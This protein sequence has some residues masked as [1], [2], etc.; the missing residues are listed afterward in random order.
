M[1]KIEKD[2]LTV[3]VVWCTANEAPQLAQNLAFAKIFGVEQLALQT[4]V[5]CTTSCNVA[6]RTKYG[7]IYVFV[8]IFGVKPS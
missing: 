7:P 1:S 5:A 4:V 8:S 2:F 3:F 6:G